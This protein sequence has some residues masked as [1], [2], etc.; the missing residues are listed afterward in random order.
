MQQAFSIIHSQETGDLGK[1]RATIMR[2]LRR[3]WKTSRVG[4]EDVVSS[5]LMHWFRGQI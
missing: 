2:T 4:V 5:A 1:V 3:Q